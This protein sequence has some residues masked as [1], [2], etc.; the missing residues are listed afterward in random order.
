MWRAET[1]R[2]A[3][4]PLAGGGLW[5]G[6]SVNHKQSRSKSKLG[7]NGMHRADA[8]AESPWGFREGSGPSEGTDKCCLSGASG[9]N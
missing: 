3:Q 8:G 6:E 4:A 5:T 1:A 2:L 9:A 7:G